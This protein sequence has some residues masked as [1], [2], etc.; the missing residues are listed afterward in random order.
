MSTQ[1]GWSAGRVA[2]LVSAGILVLAIFSMKSER[3]APSPAPTKSQVGAQGRVR[4]DGAI[5]IETIPARERRIIADHEHLLDEREARRVLKVMDRLGIRRMA[6]MGTSKYT[7]TLNDR[8]GFEKYKE[9]NEEI[10]RIAKKWPD[11]FM[12]FPTIHPTES[13]NLELLKDYVRRGA[14]GLKLYLGHG[15]STGKE[16]FH[17]M[18]LDDP[19]MKPIYAWAQETQLPI[20][21]HVNL[22]KYYDE[23]VRMMEE[24]PYLRVC[25]PHF[26]LYKNN[27]KRL[28][29]LGALLDRYP[30]MY[31]DISFGWYE[32]QLQG[33]KKFDKYPRRYRKFLEKYADRFMFSADMVVE[34]SKDDDYIINTL[35]SYIQVLE[36]PRYRLFLEPDRLMRG[37]A[38]PEET[39]RKIYWETPSRYL[40]MDEQG[41]LPD[42]T[43][44]WPWPGWEGKPMPGLPPEV[45]EVKPIH[46]PS[47]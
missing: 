25:V 4:G 36:M 1:S 5:T 22:T 43:K 35:R 38:L 30:N 46:R 33:F 37:L 6:L 31:S 26:G 28:A 44:G 2:A 34:R 29:K 23:F 20:Q 47:K 3:Q 19:R 32:F 41:N 9:N 27:R 24:F 15:A 12:A 11:R 10:L 45:P 21:F 13:G 8:Y 39:L 7:F 40:L 18:P 17:M 16:P 42:R 14:T